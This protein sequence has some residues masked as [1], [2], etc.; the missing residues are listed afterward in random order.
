LVC[1][2]AVG[3]ESAVRIADGFRPSAL[4]AR[5]WHSP[6]VIGPLSAAL[7]SSRL[8]GLDASQTRHA[9]GLAG[10]QSSGTFAAWG[11]PTVKFHQARAAVSGVLS[12][13]LAAAGFTSSPDVFGAEDGG[14]LS[15]YAGGG[16]PERITDRLGLDW[17]MHDISLRRWPTPHTNAIAAVLDLVE[18][19]TDA[20]E[21]AERI[22]VEV[23]ADA[24]AFHVFDSPTTR[25]EAMN[26]LPVSAATALLAGTF[27]QEHLQPEWYRGDE[28]RTCAKE[29]VQISVSRELPPG[30]VRA[31]PIPLQSPEHVVEQ[32]VP[33]G[34]RHRPI[35]RAS[36]VEKFVRNV[37]ARLSS[38]DATQLAAEVLA[39][40]DVD[41]VRP[42]LARAGLTT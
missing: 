32:H 17:R 30:S 14:L 11:T 5:G 33:F 7:G 38:T 29:R 6:G 36:L 22:V 23:S 31:F 13:Q 21:R 19:H 3:L 41:D 15:V 42:V 1:A 18:R 35:G 25:F 28:V 10:S 20:A 24:Q 37:G 12:A 34:S 26:S 16:D 39:L 8:L 40:D 2:V 4:R 27:D 9:L